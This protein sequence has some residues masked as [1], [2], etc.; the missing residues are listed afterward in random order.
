MTSASRP[1]PGDPPANQPAAAVLGDSAAQTRSLEEVGAAVHYHAWLTDLARPWLGDHPVELGS[2]LG[3]YAQRWL[4]RGLA[5]ITVTER[6]PGRLAGLRAR[7]ADDPR[8]DVQ[9]LDVLDA[10]A[11]NHSAFVAFNV[12]EH[13]ADDVGALGAA[14]RLVAPGGHVVMFVPAF[15]FAMSDFDRRVGH[16]RRYTR[17]SLRR[18]FDDAGLEVV[19]LHYVNAPGLPAWF[20]GMR[21]LRMTPGAGPL[22]RVWDGAVVPVARAVESL[23]RPPFGQS[24]LGIGRV[25]R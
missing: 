16:V 11:G 22:L 20:V 1:L 21:L 10:P 6:D 12:L 15:G 2:G 14:H 17:A 3:D 19:R 23:V 8:V 5:R 9:D 18:A 25:P 13:I 24:V 4:D 7:F